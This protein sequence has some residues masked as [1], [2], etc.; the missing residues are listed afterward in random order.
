M[1]KTL[2]HSFSIYKLIVI[3]FVIISNFTFINIAHAE[4]TDSNSEIQSSQTHERSVQKLYVK[5]YDQDTNEYLGRYLLAT[6]VGYTDSPHRMF[7][8]GGINPVN[9]KGYAFVGNPSAMIPVNWKNKSGITE[10]KWL[11]VKTSSDT[12]KKT[13]KGLDDSKN[14]EDSNE[15]QT[16]KLNEDGL[17]IDDDGNVNLHDIYHAYMSFLGHP[18]PTDSAGYKPTAR[19]LYLFQKYLGY[20]PSKS[21]EENYKLSTSNQSSNIN[22]SSQPKASPSISSSK[23]QS[24]H[25][26]TSIKKA[27]NKAKSNSNLKPTLEYL[28]LG[29]IG[30][31]VIL[32]I[33]RLKLK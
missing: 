8:D 14:D 30:L 17:Q 31:L 12:Y 25:K 6:Q 27:K 19:A 23:Q 5:I 13:Q 7:D 22:S 33:K 16:P 20:D 32:V 18:L 4:E 11:M 21:K 15:T 29:L 28:S 26:K 9:I 10:I 1:K 24:L 2:P 3:L